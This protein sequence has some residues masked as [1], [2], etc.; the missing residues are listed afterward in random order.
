MQKEY[1][2]TFFHFLIIRTPY[3]PWNEAFISVSLSFCPKQRNLESEQC[4]NDVLLKVTQCYCQSLVME[5]FTLGHCYWDTFDSWNLDGGAHKVP[6][7]ESILDHTLMI[8]F[9][10][11]A[12]N[13]RADKMGVRGF[14]S[15]ELY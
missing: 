6:G 5:N 11:I 2:V 14:L 13:N 7:T 12:H 3:L 10:S 4:A 8:C 15:R 9:S 1:I